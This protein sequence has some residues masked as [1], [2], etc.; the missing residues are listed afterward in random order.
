MHAILDRRCFVRAAVGLPV[1]LV[2]A[3]QAS[4]SAAAET[5]LEIGQHIYKS[6]KWNMVKLPG[7]L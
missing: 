3:G 1:A 2:W 4:R 5:G 6:L 7:S